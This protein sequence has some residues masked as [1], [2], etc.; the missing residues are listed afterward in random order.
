MKLAPIPVV[1]YWLTGEPK[2][3]EPAMSKPTLTD[4]YKHIPTY[5]GV[6]LIVAIQ[7]LVL[8]IFLRRR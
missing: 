1:R 5:G 3:K 4:W 8:L 6:A 2:E 7:T